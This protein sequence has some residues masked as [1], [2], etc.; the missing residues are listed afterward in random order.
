MINVHNAVLVFTAMCSS[1]KH[2]YNFSFIDQECSVRYNYNVSH[3]G[4]R[5]VIVKVSLDL[6]FS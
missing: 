4:P 5:E 6:L 2:G 1:L 3:P